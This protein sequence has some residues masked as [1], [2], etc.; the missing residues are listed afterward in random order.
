MS[1]TPMRDWYLTRSSAEKDVHLNFYKTGLKSVIANFRSSQETLG[2]LNISGSPDRLA[3]A[4]R[5]KVLTRSEYHL[6]RRA[7]RDVSKLPLFALVFLACGEFTPLVV[8]FMSGV[9]PWPCRIPNQVLSERRNLEERRAI[10]FR[11]LVEGPPPASSLAQQG[12]EAL[13]P[14]QALHAASSL[15]LYSRRWPEGLVGTP[16]LLDWLVKRRLRK[17]LEY[18]DLDDLLIARDGGVGQMELEEVTVALV[19]RGVDTLGKSETQ[20]KELLRI[21]LLTK[22]KSPILQLVLTRPS[23][24]QKSK[25]G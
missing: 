22:E 4:A 20:L 8:V 6:V 10:S 24:W 16:P 25:E 5:S 14:Q 9:V 18:L 21:W 12:V 19:E 17:R 13:T 2:H 23:V 7:R 11:G 1:G 15:G 3:D